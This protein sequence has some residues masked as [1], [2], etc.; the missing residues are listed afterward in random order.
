M[1]TKLIL[2]RI[3]QENNGDVGMGDFR[4][5]R[6]MAIVLLVAGSLVVIACGAATFLRYRKDDDEEADDRDPNGAVSTMVETGTT[7]TGS[8]TKTITA[9]ESPRAVGVACG[10]AHQN[11]TMSNVG[12]N[13]KRNMTEKEYLN[14]GTAVVGGRMTIAGLRNVN[15]GVRTG[16]PG[17]PCDG[18][19]LDMSAGTPI[20][21]V[22][23]HGSPT[24]I[25]RATN[26]SNV[27][28]GT[29]TAPHSACSPLPADQPAEPGRVPQSY[30]RN[31]DIIPAPLMSPRI[32]YNNYNNK[33]QYIY[34]T[35]E[36]IE[37]LFIVPN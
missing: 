23:S 1:C 7:I 28:Y 11:N 16:S 6:A 35:D 9:D 29:K 17:V 8:G 36:N 33:G 24:S 2:D 27:L 20:A 19:G 21:F 13:N 26:S 14:S 34:K 25:L 30:H 31:P 22:P 37:T 3:S 12:C 10:V 15:I 18:S 32:V 4:I 5:T